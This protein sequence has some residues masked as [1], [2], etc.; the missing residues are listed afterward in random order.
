MTAAQVSAA[1]TDILD[2]FT[3]VV[4]VIKILCSGP[5]HPI[6]TGKFN[7]AVVVWISRY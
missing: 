5:Q 4:K 7:A 1:L 2:K 3:A 6:A